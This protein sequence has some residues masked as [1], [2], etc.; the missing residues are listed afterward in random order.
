MHGGGTS[1]SPH[2]RP[3]GCYNPDTKKYSVKL[4]AKPTSYRSAV[5]VVE[6]CT[7]ETTTE[8]TVEEVYAKLLEKVEEKM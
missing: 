3:I 5:V 7:M 2:C 1:N 6:A 8:P 4:F